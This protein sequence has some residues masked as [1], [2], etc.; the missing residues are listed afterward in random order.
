MPTV[1]TTDQGNPGRLYVGMDERGR[2]LEIVAVEITNE[3]DDAAVLLV[4][5]VM[6]TQLRRRGPHD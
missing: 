6:P 3:A 5:H 1:I 2:E 4:L